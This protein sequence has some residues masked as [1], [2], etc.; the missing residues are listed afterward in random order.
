MATSNMNLVTPVPGDTDYPTKTADNN[1]LV[2]AHDHT[3]GK[4]VQIPAAGIADGAISADKIAASAV[5]TAK[6]LDAAVTKAKLAALGQQTV[7]L[8]GSSFSTTSATAV[9]VTGMSVSITTTG[10]P[11]MVVVTAQIALQR[12]IATGAIDMQGFL[13]VLRGASL[14][15]YS[16]PRIAF[17]TA[18]TGNVDFTG[19]ASFCYVDAPVAGSYTYKLQASANPL[20]TNTTAVILQNSVLTVYEL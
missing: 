17:P 20:D 14:L 6:I 10:R 18:S 2:D 4:G 9:D 19:Q 8:S 11:V 12:A 15:A 16:N 1:N 5:S 7:V 13:S 3:S